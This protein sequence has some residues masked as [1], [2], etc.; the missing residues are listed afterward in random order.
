MSTIS[1]HPIGY[2]ADKTIAWDKREASSKGQAERRLPMQ[3]TALRPHQPPQ[4]SCL[5]PLTKRDAIALSAPP[6]GIVHRVSQTAL[7]TVYQRPSNRAC[8]LLDRHQA[9]T[10]FKAYGRTTASHLFLMDPKN[11]QLLKSLDNMLFLGSTAAQNIK[12]SFPVISTFWG[13]VSSNEAGPMIY[14]NFLIL[15]EKAFVRPILAAVHTWKQDFNRFGFGSD[16]NYKCELATSFIADLQNTLENLCSHVLEKCTSNTTNDTNK[17]IYAYLWM[18]AKIQIPALI[19]CL[20]REHLEQFATNHEKARDKALHLK[21]L[22]EESARVKKI[23]TTYASFTSGERTLL[24]RQRQWVQK[25]PSQVPTW[26]EKL[27]NLEDQIRKINGGFDCDLGDPQRIRDLIPEE[28]QFDR[29][30][31]AHFFNVEPLDPDEKFVDPVKF[32]MT[33]LL[34]NIRFKTRN[35]LLFFIRHVQDTAPVPTA[36]AST[37]TA[38]AGSEQ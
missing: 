31:R 30:V 14:Q 3:L 2:I 17:V 19:N 28:S 27:K 36:T 35:R 6:N 25:A 9:F 33:H 21:G 37:A 22:K 18:Q 32:T 11:V 16:L 23:L 24:P 15:L 7:T 10:L 26:Q 13:M 34:K 29:A 20:V 12:E 4:T 1:K 8:S 5:V 38:A